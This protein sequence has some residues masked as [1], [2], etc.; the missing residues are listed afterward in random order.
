MRRSL[1]EATFSSMRFPIL[2]AS[3]SPASLSA[4]NCL[5]CA[6]GPICDTVEICCVIESELAHSCKVA[7]LSLAR[8]PLS[9]YLWWEP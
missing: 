7:L 8:W 3:Y 2:S 1:F 9:H 5:A 6:K 4:M